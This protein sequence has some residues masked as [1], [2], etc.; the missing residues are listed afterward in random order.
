MMIFSEIYFLPIAV[1]SS[2]INLFQC[3]VMYLPDW[4][5]G[6]ENW[7]YSI[8]VFCCFLELGKW[9]KEKK[10]KRKKEEKQKECT[11]GEGEGRGHF[12]LLF[13][14]ILIFF[15]MWTSHSGKSLFLTI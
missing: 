4:S 6:W 8:G 12:C 15:L 3:E 11:G 14:L 5:W 10:K 13:I 7:F 2:S 1:L 9:K